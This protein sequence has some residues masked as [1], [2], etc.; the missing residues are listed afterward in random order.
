MCIFRLSFTFVDS[1]LASSAFQ[2]IGSEL[3][4]TL[5]IALPPCH[6][7]RC[8]FRDCETFPSR[9]EV[10]PSSHL[11]IDRRTPFLFQRLWLLLKP[12]MG[13]RILMDLKPHRGAPA[14]AKAHDGAPAQA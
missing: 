4:A 3:E 2:S 13:L 14:Q 8:E 11:D 1:R 5:S 7:S 12:T 9:N 10:L 6:R